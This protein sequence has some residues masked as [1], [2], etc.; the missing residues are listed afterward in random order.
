MKSTWIVVA[1]SARARIFTMSG[2]GGRLQEIAD[3]SHPESRL[4]DTELTSDLPGRAFDSHG[5]GRHAMEQATDPKEREAQVFAVEISRY[6]DRGRR[7]GSF[8]SLVL[9]APPKF[10][11][12]LRPELSKTVRGTLIGELDKNLVEADGKTLERHLSALLQ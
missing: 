5:Q 1:E 9:V 10:L 4:H 11:G 12:R 8:D 6:I 7:E 2:A 3:L